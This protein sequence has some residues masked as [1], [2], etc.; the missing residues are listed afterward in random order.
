MNLL[1][2]RID[3]PIC[4]LPSSCFSAENYNEVILLLSARN[5]STNRQRW[6]SVHHWCTVLG[7]FC[8][9]GSF[10]IPHWGFELLTRL[11]ASVWLIPMFF[12]K[13][14]RSLRDGTIFCASQDIYFF[15]NKTSI[16]LPY[17]KKWGLS[18]FGSHPTANRWFGTTWE[19][20]LSRIGSWSLARG[21]WGIFLGC[22]EVGWLTRLT[23]KAIN[24]W[25]SKKG[26]HNFFGGKTHWMH[27]M[28]RLKGNAGCRFFMFFFRSWRLWIEKELA[29]VV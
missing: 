7:K 19:T 18:L 3:Y 5:S 11:I 6:I 16:F 9:A 17:Q 20:S 15:V 25:E 2:G 21:P 14:I 12:V 1:A 22:H 13:S 29:R 23:D 28:Q 8:Y 10:S 24:T 27:W 4:Y 26:G